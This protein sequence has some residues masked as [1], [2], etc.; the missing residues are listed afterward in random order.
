METAKIV[1]TGQSQ[2]VELPKEYQFDVEQV[3]IRRQGNAVI[4]E[5][6]PQNWDWLD[7]VVGSVDD[8]F[9][10]A[11]AEHPPQQDR[12]ELDYLK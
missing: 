4:I 12:S 11:V 3:Q 7:E 5:P 2:A 6:L 8:D 1:W 9:E 10:Q